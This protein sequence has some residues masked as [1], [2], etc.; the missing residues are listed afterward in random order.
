MLNKIQTYLTNKLR[1]RE[2]TLTNKFEK[3]NQS[4]GYKPKKI[5]YEN[6]F[7]FDIK[8]DPRVRI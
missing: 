6:M 4:L 7:L 1:I 8:F 3:K 5:H 2:I